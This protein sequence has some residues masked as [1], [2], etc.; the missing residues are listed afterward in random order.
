VE[1]VEPMGS[2]TYVYLRIGDTTFISRV[3][4]H[5]RFRVGD[6]TEL[7]VLMQKAHFFDSRTEQR[8]G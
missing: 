7:G 4:A 5:R 1:V 2:E 8:L 3:D 6:T